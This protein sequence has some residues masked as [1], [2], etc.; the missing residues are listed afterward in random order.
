MEPSK[1]T[2]LNTAACGLV[3]EEVASAGNDFTLGLTANGS[4]RSEQ[5]RQAEEGRIRDTVAAFLGTRKEKIAIVPNFSWALNAI[6]Q[7]LDPALKVM[8]YR[9][10]YPSVLEPFRINGFPIDWIDTNDGF[11]LPVEQIEQAIEAK[12]IDILAISHVQ[13]NSGYKLDIKRIGSLCRKHDVLFI[14]DATQS[15]GAVPLDM[16]QLETDILIASNYKWMNAGFGTGI[17][18]MSDTFLARHTPVVG[19]HNSYQMK[20]GKWMY[21]PSVLSYEPGHPNMYG[22]LLLEAAIHQKQK[23][24]IDNIET[25]N[26]E[27][28]TLLLGHLK[29]I[30]VQLIGPFTMENRASIVIL[31]DEHGLSG[32][33]KEN[34]I[35]VT[36]RNG[37]VRISMHF[38]NTAEEIMRLVDV[39]SGFTKKLQ[40]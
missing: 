9:Q 38:Y 37:I 29:S 28:T 34:D 31:K 26:K 30:P 40:A 36:N 4:A 21:V 12:A 6:V 35:I 11:T 5:W 18:Y 27:L 25:H 3:A 23:L 10:D 33:L 22:Q 8:L 39:L 24:G 20:D 16:A 2:Y 7:S 14:V 19:G 17:L 15:M 32:W 1:I 13:F